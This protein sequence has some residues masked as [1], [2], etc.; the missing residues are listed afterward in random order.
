[1]M[2]NTCMALEFTFICPLPN[3]IHARPASHLAALAND[4]ISDCAM[5]NARNGSTANM[6]SVLS[7]IAADIRLHDEC[8]VRV[9]GADEQVAW[10]ALRHF[11]GKDLPAYDVPLVLQDQKSRGLPR[12]LRSA[13][14]KAYSGLPVSRGIG[15]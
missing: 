11:V 7:I 4:F 3:G 6:K 10:A 13:G 9:Q 14:V 1:M 5:T 12:F 8:S 2:Q 15:L